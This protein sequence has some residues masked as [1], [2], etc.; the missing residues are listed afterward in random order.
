MIGMSGSQQDELAAGWMWRLFPF[1]SSPDFVLHLP[2]RKDK[3]HFTNKVP[4]QKKTV[5]RC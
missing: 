4:D 3:N 1:Y 5:Q 2:D